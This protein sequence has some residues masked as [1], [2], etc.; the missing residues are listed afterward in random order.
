MVVNNLKYWPVKWWWRYVSYLISQ[1]LHLSW[2]SINF[3]QIK[4]FKNIYCYIYWVVCDFLKFENKVYF[5]HTTLICD[6]KN[7]THNKYHINSSTFSDIK[8]K[9]PLLN[10]VTCLLKFF[11]QTH[12][13][14][15]PTDAGGD[16]NANQ[17][18]HHLR[19]MRPG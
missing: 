12:Q 15:A 8:I 11:P 19:V 10:V 5:P 16:H 9:M 6:L 14:R 1:S 17:L 7:Q 3:R 4:H 13:Q 2:V 18:D